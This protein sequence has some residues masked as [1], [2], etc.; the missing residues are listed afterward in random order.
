MDNHTILDEKLNQFYVSGPMGR[1]QAVFQ[2][3]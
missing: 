3:Q 1:P 2:G